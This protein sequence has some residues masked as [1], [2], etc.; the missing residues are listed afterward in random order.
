[1]PGT[2]ST[3]ECGGITVV[4][5]IDPLA[6]RVENS[7]L[8]GFGRYRKEPP[9]LSCLSK[10]TKD[11]EPCSSSGVSFC[12]ILVTFV[13]LG[14]NVTGAFVGSRGGGGARKGLK[15][16]FDMVSMLGGSIVKLDLQRIFENAE[17]RLEAG[18]AR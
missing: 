7:F 12:L 10:D 6:F 13:A 9:C 8:A 16:C 15:M 14:V 3:E 17:A 1:V 4:V 18:R 5:V 11:R 2:T